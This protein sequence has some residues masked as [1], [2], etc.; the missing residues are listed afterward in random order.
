MKAWLVYWIIGSVLVGAA[1]GHTVETCQ[2][3]KEMKYKEVLAT[4][5]LWPAPVV[6]SILYDIPQVDDLCDS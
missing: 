1:W 3:V 6:A 4:V 2:E 5:L